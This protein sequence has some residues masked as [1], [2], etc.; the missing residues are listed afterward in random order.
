MSIIV[1]FTTQFLR[2]IWQEFIKGL[3]KIRTRW[4]NRSV[5]DC[6]FYEK[7][8]RCKIREFGKDSLKVWENCLLII[9]EN[10]NFGKNGEFG[11]NL[12]KVWQKLKQD[13]KRRMSLIA[14]SYENAIFAKPTNFLKNSSKVWQNL[15]ENKKNGHLVRIS[16]IRKWQS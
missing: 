9:S 8:K 13:D 10:S 7:D 1:S 4:R 2:Q 6:G 15:N 14:G 11:K 16:I 12:S 5:D 3:V